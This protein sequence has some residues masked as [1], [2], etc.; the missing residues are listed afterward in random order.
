[1]ML[2]CFFGYVVKETVSEDDPRGDYSEYLGPNWKKELKD[3]KA[4]G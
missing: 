3:F 2:F 4:S 1:M